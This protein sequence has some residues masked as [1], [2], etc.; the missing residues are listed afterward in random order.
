MRVCCHIIT[1]R[2]ESEVGIVDAY[3]PHGKEVEK[4]VHEEMLDHHSLQ[5]SQKIGERMSQHRKYSPARGFCIVSA[6]SIYCARGTYLGDGLNDDDVE[7]SP[8]YV[9]V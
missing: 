9:H 3:Y 2:E 6:I 8:H 4:G 5:R 7:Y 1:A